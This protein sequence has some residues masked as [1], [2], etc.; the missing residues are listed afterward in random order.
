MMQKKQIN[1]VGL[2]RTGEIL[3]NQ[4]PCPLQIHKLKASPPSPSRARAP[5][6]LGPNQLQVLQG[7]QE[8]AAERTTNSTNSSNSNEMQRH[9]HKE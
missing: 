2:Y 3:Q 9:Q 1:C 5:R 4:S 8:A 6:R 7:L